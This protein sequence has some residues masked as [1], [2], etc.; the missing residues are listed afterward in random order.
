MYVY[1]GIIHGY[2]ILIVSMHVVWWLGNETAALLQSHP[3]EAL[4]LLQRHPKQ[5]GTLTAPVL[6]ALLQRQH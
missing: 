1:I 6:M 3:N 2:I 4:A 5:N